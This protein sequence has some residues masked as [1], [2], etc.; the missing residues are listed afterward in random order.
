MIE[1]NVAYSK[2]ICPCYQMVAEYVIRHLHKKWNVI[3]ALLMVII[4]L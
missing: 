3:R 1:V 2:Y 4:I